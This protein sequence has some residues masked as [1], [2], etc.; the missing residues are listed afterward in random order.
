MWFLIAPVPVHCFSFPFFRQRF[1]R[2]FYAYDFEIWYKPGICQVVLC[3]RESAILCLSFPL[4]VDFS[5]SLIN[6]S[7]THSLAHF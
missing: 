3:V 2:D 4:Y 1:L 6:I 7:V 5:F